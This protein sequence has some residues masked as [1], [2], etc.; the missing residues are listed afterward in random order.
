MELSDHELIYC[1][2][3]ASLLKLNEHYEISFRSLINYS[4]EIFVDKLR[5]LKFPY[6]SKHTCV[7]HIYQD[8]VTKFLSAAD[9]ASRIRTLRVKSNTKPW[10][11]I[12]VLNTIRNCDKHYKKFKQSVKETDKDNFKYERLSL[13]Q[14]Y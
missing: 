13:K 5:L 12:D 14:N 4:D 2:R 11:D 9:S 10:V 7:N 8:F 1:S 3:R 6:Y